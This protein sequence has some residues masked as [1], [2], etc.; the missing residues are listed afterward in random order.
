ME[1]RL[2]YKIANRYLEIKTE[3]P[4]KLA[5]LLPGFGHFH[6]SSDS[7]ESLIHLVREGESE[8]ERLMQPDSETKIIH[9]FNIE[10]DIC[11][12]SK[13]GDNYFFTITER[14]G[15]V[16]AEFSMEAESSR[17]KCRLVPDYRDGTILLSNP[18]HL[19]FALW[20]IFGFRGIPRKLS[21]IHSS[22]IVY[23]KSAVLFLGESGTGKSTHTRLWLENIPG[24]TLL[25]DDSPI[26]SI[27]EGMPYVHGSP[28]SG[29]GQKYLNESYPLKAVVRIRQN[30]SNKIQKLNTLESFGA[31]YP[32][33]PPAYLKD[34]FFEG[35]IC[36]MISDIITTT[37]VYH[38]YC[39]PDSDAALL[40]KETLY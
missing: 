10:Q 1:N 38:L 16:S 17:V 9:T 8:E 35:H 20:M 33:F 24:S 31:L 3:Y 28:W 26:L 23:N 32:S 4:E 39:L 11:R 27:E 15:S 5:K 12:F 30:S 40:V 7:E 25:N 21:A 13:R 2:K 36:E 29:K 19:K 22:V 18:V 37:P 6:D 34:S 14:G